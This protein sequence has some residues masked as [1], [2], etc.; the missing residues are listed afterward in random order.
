[1]NIEILKHLIKKIL[2]HIFYFKS[3]NINMSLIVKFN[4]MM[5]LTER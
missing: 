4:K 3:Y 1:M 2:F 5:I